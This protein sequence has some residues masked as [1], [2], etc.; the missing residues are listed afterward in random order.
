MFSL[1]VVD[2]DAFL[3]MP[4][5]SQL[6]YFHLA[7]RAD[8]DGFVPNPKKIMRMIGNPDDDMK[9][10][11]AKKFVL[12]FESGVC[13]IKH[14]RIHNYIQSDRKVDTQWI[15]EMEMLKVDEKTKKYSL[16]KPSDGKCIQN[17]YKLDTQVRLGKVRLG[18]VRLDISEEIKNKYS[19]SLLTDF[20]LYWEETDAKNIPRWKKEKTWDLEKRLIRW[21]R[22]QEKWDYEKNQ[23]FLIKKM[24]M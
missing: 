1:K 12:I 18:K 6:L 2:T 20:K 17:G 19:P 24:S 8:D 3:D 16:T 9:V 15:K 22:N 14:W 21:Q 7:M 10:L 5:S 11:L 13:V 4:Q 23:K